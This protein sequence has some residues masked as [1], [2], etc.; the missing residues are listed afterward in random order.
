MAV[1][2]SLLHFQ[3]K[4]STTSI[5]HKVCDSNFEYL[6][7]MAEIYLANYPFPNL[8]HNIDHVDILIFNW[9]D[10]L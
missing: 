1:R 8:S 7:V 6:T 5:S 2:P 10:V 9:S 4:I 3:K